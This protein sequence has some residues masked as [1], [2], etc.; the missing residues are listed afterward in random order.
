MEIIEKLKESLRLTLPYFDL[1]ADELQQSYGPGKWNIRQILHHLAD[2][3]TI[4]Y[5]RVRRIIAEP[6]QV[7]W[8]FDQD[9]WNVQLNYLKVPL[10]INKNI[11]RST[12][13]AVIYYAG[14]Y[15]I[16][17]A[18]KEFVHS[19]T[20]VRTLKDEFDKIAAHN[21]SHIAQI[22]RALKN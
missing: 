21:F 5:E 16:P 2:A 6:R 18:G 14:E 15:Y 3:E 20:G 10:E 8:A 11:Y 13:E 22:E 7:I 17:L 19:E 1:S 9:M 12:R 4:L